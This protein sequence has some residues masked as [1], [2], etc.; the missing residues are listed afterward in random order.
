M[1]S[2]PPAGTFQMSPRIEKAIQR[3]SGL[4][5]GSIGPVE[6]GGSRW[7]STRVAWAG[8]SAGIITSARRRIGN[9]RRAE[10]LAV[11]TKTT[12][13]VV[14]MARWW[15]VSGPREYTMK[16]GFRG[17]SGWPLPSRAHTLAAMV[18]DFISHHLTL[19]YELVGLFAVFGAFIL[20]GAFVLSR[21][22][23]TS[24]EDAL[25]FAFVTALTLGL[26]DITPNSRGGRVVTVM[27]AFLGF[28]LIGVFVAI[29]AEALSRAISVP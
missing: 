14:M 9:R 7:N 6:T 25:Y 4:H 11:P 15:Q 23:N 27:L 2:P 3:P 10:R 28:V 19:M 18:T 20:G 26:G 22:E 29:A 1:A 5:A 21:F 17:S 8:A 12:F 16:S 24:M 13:E